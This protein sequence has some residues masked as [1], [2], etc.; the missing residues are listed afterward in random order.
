MVKVNGSKFGLKLTS[1]HIWCSHKDLAHIHSY[2]I[3]KNMFGLKFETD[4]VTTFHI[5]SFW[6]KKQIRV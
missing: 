4:F 3:W 2:S 5:P 1:L 6:E